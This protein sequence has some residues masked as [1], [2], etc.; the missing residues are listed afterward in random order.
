MPWLLFIGAVVL[1]KG[2][3]GAV[4]VWDTQPGYGSTTIPE[5]QRWLDQ[6]PHICGVR[7][8]TIELQACMGQLAVAARST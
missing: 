7:L 2:V 4:F 5:N 8:K 3:G 1:I 6:R